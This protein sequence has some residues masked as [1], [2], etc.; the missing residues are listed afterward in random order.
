MLGITL[1][2]LAAAWIAL[3]NGLFVPLF[4]PLALGWAFYLACTGLAYFQERTQRLRTSTMFKRFLD[5]RV[6]SDL[7]DRGEI[8]H[9][10]HA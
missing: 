7:S 1:A 10:N 2:L 9:R 4:A 3:I 6:V 8:D 5:P